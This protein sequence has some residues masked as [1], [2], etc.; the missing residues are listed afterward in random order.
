[1]K[2]IEQERY[3]ASTNQDVTQNKSTNFN[4]FLKEL[5][6]GA[7]TISMGKQFH[8]GTTMTANEDKWYSIKIMSK[9][10]G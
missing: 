9:V 8:S 3:C 5:R 6:L 10:W 2:D 4:L 7:Q 1:M